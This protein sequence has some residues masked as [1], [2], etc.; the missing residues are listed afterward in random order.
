M[1][2]MAL[3]SAVTAAYQGGSGCFIP[4]SIMT[5]SAEKQGQPPVRQD[6][7]LTPRETAILRLVAAGCTNSHIARMLH[8]SS[9][10]V[11]QHIAGMLHR[12]VSQNRSELVA[13]AYSAGILVTGTW[14]PE[15][16][17]GL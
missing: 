16:R 15:A 1:R 11:A 17:H 4:G 10:T 8:I 9:H 3:P 2:G 6:F 7:R 14:P 12:T 13:R 5:V